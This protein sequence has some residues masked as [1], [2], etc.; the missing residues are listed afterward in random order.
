MESSPP[1]NPPTLPVSLLPLQAPQDATLACMELQ[2][3]LAEC[4][5]MSV[6][7]IKDVLNHLDKKEIVP[8]RQTDDAAA[9]QNFVLQP[10]RSNAAA[11][12]DLCQCHEVNK[13]KVKDFIQCC[14]SEVTDVSLTA[15][16]NL[17]IIKPQLLWIIDTDVCHL[18]AKIC[19]Q[20]KK[21][22]QL[23][24]KCGKIHVNYLQ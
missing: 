23:E 3:L 11:A 17:E 4:D 12:N 13:H 8:L 1:F 7:T 9:F 6:P 21:I 10:I 2:K 19:F 22:C 16:N 20:D 24:I 15:N 18:V 5:D 14:F